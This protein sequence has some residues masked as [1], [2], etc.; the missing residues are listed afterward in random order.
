MIGDGM[1][2][3]PGVYR[4]VDP[5]FLGWIAWRVQQALDNPQTPQGPL[6]QAISFFYEVPPS[7][8]R[9]VS[10]AITRIQRQLIR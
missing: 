4:Q 1:G 7:W 5:E 2:V 6:S 8:R 9:M 10:G 3:P